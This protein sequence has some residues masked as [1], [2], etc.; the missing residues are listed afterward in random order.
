MSFL[1]SVWQQR[2]EEIYPALFGDIGQGIYTLPHTIFHDRFG[3]KNVDP[4]WFHH[5]V[6]KSPPNPK[7]TTWLYVSSGMSN[8]WESDEKEDI[9]GLGVE[10]VLETLSDEFW[11][12]PLLH[13]L[14]AFNI[15]LSVGQFGEKPLL[16]PGDRIPQPLKPNLTHLMLG[17][18]TD[19]PETFE[20]ASG[21]AHLLQ[22]VGITQRE[23]DYAQE[24]GSAALCE[25]LKI[26]GIYPVTNP[27]RDSTTPA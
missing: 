1:E 26:S 14:I 8:P 3:Y 4:R 23:F 15:M 21:K 19:F 5:G 6:F 27:N 13:S 25:R 17:A 2:E 24:Q 10:L 16:G 12:I 18:P 7:R 9:S 22:V 20:M 11:A